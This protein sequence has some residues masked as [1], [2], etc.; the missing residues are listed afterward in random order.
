MALGAAA[1]ACMS[2]L[3][4]AGTVVFSDG[5]STAPDTGLADIGTWSDVSDEVDGSHRFDIASNNPQ[6]RFPSKP[7]NDPFLQM[8]SFSTTRFDYTATGTAGFTE[9]ATAGDQAAGSAA[10][11]S[12][13]FREQNGRVVAPG[14]DLQLTL[15]A[16]STVAA[17]YGVTSG[18]RADGLDTLA[19]DANGDDVFTDGGTLSG[20]RSIVWA[21]NASAAPVL[22]SGGVLASGQ[23]VLRDLG[24]P[25]DSTAVPTVVT[26]GL[27][28]VGAAVD[29]LQFVVEEGA[30]GTFPNYW[31]DDLRV[32]TLDV[33]A[34]IPEPVSVAGASL[35]LG[36]GL[37]RRRLE[38]S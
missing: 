38:M 33:A 21:Y 4:S 35:L 18:P 6:S 3:A 9:D 12:F 2:S 14:Q 22:F 23:W 16:G 34:A 1:A 37:R 10:E 27:V 26:T 20:P 31:V 25:N 5:F 30:S 28:T 17:S 11:V 15:L 7:I 24:A 36:I 32:E 8:V 19:Y 29:S 13:L